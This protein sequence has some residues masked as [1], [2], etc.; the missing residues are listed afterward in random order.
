[1]AHNRVE[2]VLGAGNIGPPKYPDIGSARK[3]GEMFRPHGTRI[4]HARIY[5]AD[6]PGQVEELM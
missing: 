3:Y 5:P 1:M 2:V 6:E 4:D